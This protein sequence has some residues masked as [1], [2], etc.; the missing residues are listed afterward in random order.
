MIPNL[1][2]LFRMQKTKY[3]KYIGKPILQH[4]FLIQKFYVGLN[5]IRTV[6]SGVLQK[7]GQLGKILKMRI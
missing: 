7:M 1:D 4:T 2:L 5:Y 3:S 6:S